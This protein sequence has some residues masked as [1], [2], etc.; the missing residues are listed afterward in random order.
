MGEMQPTHS[1]T[2]TVIGFPAG[3]AFG[4]E[5]LQFKENGATRDGVCLRRLLLFGSSFPPLP[6]SL[7]LLNVGTF[8][9][10]S[11][12]RTA[13]HTKLVVAQLVE[14]LSTFLQNSN[15]VHCRA[16]RSTQLVPMQSQTNPIPSSH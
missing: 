12:H 15:R 5:R 4:P 2:E 7:S 6:L 11:P 14:K 16:H 1:V 8:N 3:P 13:L 10:S 9:G